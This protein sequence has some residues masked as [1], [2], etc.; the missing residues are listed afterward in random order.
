MVPSS[1]GFDSNVELP[2]GLTIS[3]LRKSVEYIERELADLVE[4]YLEQRNVF[5]ALVGI[6]GTK[7]LDQHSP[8]EKVRHLDIQQTRFPDLCLRGTN[9]KKNFRC[10]LESKGSKRPWSLQS[11]Y[12]HEGWYIVWRYL[13]DQTQQIEP[14]KPVIVWRIDVVY[15]TKDDWKYEASKAGAGGGGRTHTFG[16]KSPRNRLRG[17]HVYQRPDIKLLRSKPVHIETHS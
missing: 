16:V 9:P 14:G 4:I 11:H 13:V 15:L 12:D 6:F 8:Y 10:C 5:S 7:A 2:K 3:A 17:C 1:D